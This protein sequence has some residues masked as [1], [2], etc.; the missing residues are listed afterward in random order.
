LTDHLHRSLARL[1]ENWRSPIYQFFLS[2]VTVGHDKGH[3]FH[4]F[5]CAATRCRNK[6]IH[7]V[8]R[9]QD[10]KDRGAT[11]NLKTHAIKCF[12][13]DAVVAAFVD[14]LTGRQDGSIFAAFA[15][16]GQAPVKV[17]HQAHTTD[18]TR[19]VV[20]YSLHSS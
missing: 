10:S 20:M 5:K 16:Q 8:R 6:G 12:G 19:Q 15:R 13:K 11:S 17:T 4:F 1:K 18:E 7:G 3:K 2:E 14:N 9:Y